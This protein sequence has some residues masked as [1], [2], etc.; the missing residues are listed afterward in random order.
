MK[1][2]GR[3]DLASELLEDISEKTGGE[4]GISVKKSTENG[5]DCTLVR[6]LNENGSAL[7]G[8]DI[9]SYFTLELPEGSFTAKECIK[10]L[11]AFLSTLV[12]HGSVLVSALGNPDITPDALGPL[13]AERI[14]VTRHLRIASPKL[15][16]HLRETSLCRAGVLSMGG[17]ESAQQIK[18][19][20][21]IT[22][23]D[24]II[25]I[26]ALAGRNVSMLCRSIQI[27]D[28]GISPGS[29][30]GNNRERISRGTL[31][32][33]V[34]SIGVPT[35]TDAF[36][37]KGDNKEGAMFVTPRDIDLR[38]RKLSRIIACAINT[39]L[40]PTLSAEEIEE[41]TEE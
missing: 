17:I 5:F 33:P 30:V 27:S 6:V 36:I 4:H 23:P 18:A 10:P 39:A 40:Q 19:A 38:V 12:G 32:I 11:S 35:V 25:V 7:L 15:F 21:E 41:L 2:R 28:T 16:A 3:T 29:G 13:T 20:A 26:D 22:H 8:R 24:C 9:G 34:I 1:F 37:D 14:L 31:G